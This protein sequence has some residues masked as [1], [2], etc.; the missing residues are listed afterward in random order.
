MLNLTLSFFG[1]LDHKNFER[2]WFELSNPELGDV[3]F[4]NHHTKTLTEYPRYFIQ[5]LCIRREVYWT[6]QQPTVFSKTRRKFHWK[7]CSQNWQVER[8]IA[9]RIS[10]LQLTIKDSRFR[11]IRNENVKRASSSNWFCNHK[12]VLILSPSLKFRSIKKEKE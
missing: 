11:P 2:G 8:E 9:R 7:N 12:Y 3:T 10:A 6:R 4:V 5:S 1:C